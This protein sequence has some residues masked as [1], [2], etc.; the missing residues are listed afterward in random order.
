MKY[1]REQ[2]DDFRSNTPTYVQWLLLGAAILIVV[3]L[4]TLLLSREKPIDPSTIRK[5]VEFDIKPESIKFDNV[6]V[7]DKITQLLIFPILKPNVKI[8]LTEERGVCG[9][10]STN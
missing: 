10:G 8:E 1:I 9:F 6:K 7:G 2:F 3:I 4:L 5:P